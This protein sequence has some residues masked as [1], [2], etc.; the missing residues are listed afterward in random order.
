MIFE[1]AGATRTLKNHY[2]IE[3]PIFCQYR[4]DGINN[5]FQNVSIGHGFGSCA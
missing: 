3:L 5:I 4:E 2:S 1:R